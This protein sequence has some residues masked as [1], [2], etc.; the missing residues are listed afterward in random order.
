MYEVFSNSAIVRFD[1]CFYLYWDGSVYQLDR[2]FLH[3]IANMIIQLLSNSPE[4][5][6]C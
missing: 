4:V 1:T 6:F 2:P 5:N 3:N